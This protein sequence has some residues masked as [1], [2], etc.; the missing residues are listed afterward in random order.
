[1]EQ[2]SHFL[3]LPL[4]VKLVTES[5]IIVI[6][7]TKHLEKDGPVCLQNRRR[8]RGKC[9]LELGEIIFA[10]CCPLECLIGAIMTSLIRN[11]VVQL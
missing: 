10:D 4:T 8:E 1:M 11:C 2:L 7:G 5:L 9:V 6:S 3:Y